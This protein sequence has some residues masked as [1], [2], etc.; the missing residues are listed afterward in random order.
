MWPLKRIYFILLA[1]MM[2]LA[3]KPPFFIEAFELKIYD[4]L[5]RYSAPNQPD[6]RIV[7]VGIDQKSL[8]NFGRWPWSRDVIGRLVEK[9]A[10]YGV[11]VT[12]L[13]MT[14]SSQ[15][16]TATRDILEKVGQAAVR[17]G[18][19]EKIPSFNQELEK[20]RQE[21]QKDM[22]LAGSMRKAGNVVTGFVFHGMDE[23]EYSAEVEE[24]KLPIVQPFRIKLVQRDSESRDASL[25]SLAAGVEPNIQAIQ[26]AGSATGFLNTLTDEDGVIRAHPMVM[27]YKGDL[28]PSLGLA[29]AA[30]YSGDTGDIQAYFADG[31]FD[32]VAIGDS[33]IKMDHYGRI[34]LK[35]L[36]GVDTFPT[37]SAA[38]VLLKPVD[39]EGLRRKLS[40]KLAFVGA[41]ATQ[42]YDLRVTPIGYT[43]GVQVQATSASNALT[44]QVISKEAWQTLYDPVL[45]AVAG[46]ALFFILRRVRVALGLALTAAMLALLVAFNYYMFAE[47]H[48][49]LNSVTPGMMILFGFITITTH[50]YITEQKSK[51]FIKDAFGRYLS[52][53][54]INQIIDNPG[55]LKLG[56]DKRVMTAYFSDVAGFTTVSEKLPPTELVLLLNEYLSAMTDIIHTFD[57]TVD[58]YEGDAIIAFWNAPI[59]V[60]NH[61]ELCVRSA[62]AMQRK[63]E[64]MR[65]KWRSEGRDELHVRMGINTGPMVVGNM[66]SRERMDYTMMGD[67]VNLAARLE[68]VN[69]YY[70]TYI[71]VSQFTRDMVADR[72][73]CR[74]LDMVRVQGKKEAIKLYEVVEA[75]EDSIETQRRFVEMFHRAIRTFRDMDFL[76]AQEL[77]SACDKLKKGGDGACKLYLK[78]CAELIASPPAQDWDRVYDMAK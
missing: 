52:P 2:A 44:G 11:K 27:E 7:I 12:A 19:V 76:K 17:T 15:A 28:Y 53:K 78:R 75:M 3:F 24:R 25:L 37:I 36:G 69:K 70:G 71:L 49:W 72:F 20:L 66:G 68:G 67:S 32:G 47:N 55:L 33:F 46:M 41:T 77:F 34:F 10:G 29:A 31:M 63:L 23:A 21:T 42:I 5:I 59:M 51:R 65:G 54:V 50:Q 4:L 48:L 61:A 60:E 1:A 9:L 18:A 39:D 73:L 38:D 22:A 40:G 58:K 26:E 30:A 62:V 16:D 64:A 13:D 43:A 14:F 6:P 8:D 74:E 45:T 35:Y 56:G 57:G